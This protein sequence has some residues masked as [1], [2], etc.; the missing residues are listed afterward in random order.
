MFAAV[1]AGKTYLSPSISHSVI[2]SYLHRTGSGRIFAALT[3]Q[4]G[5]NIIVEAKGDTLDI[6]VNNSSIMPNG[7]VANS[8]AALDSNRRGDLLFQ[9]ANG[10][11]N[12]LLVL[13]ANEASKIRQVINLYRPTAEGDYLVRINA[14]DFRDDGTVYFLAMTVDDETVLYEAKPLP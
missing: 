12:F 8:V 9:Q 3:I 1:L 2:D 13:P 11:N 7:Q 10:G 14:I 5:G 4:A 6:L